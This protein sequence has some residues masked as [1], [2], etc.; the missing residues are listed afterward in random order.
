VHLGLDRQLGGCE[1]ILDRRTPTTAVLGFIGSDGIEVA[2]F[3]EPKG[4][5]TISRK[6]KAMLIVSATRAKQI[7]PLLGSSSAG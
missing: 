1:S 5:G 3:N 4:P 7:H 6:P 2:E